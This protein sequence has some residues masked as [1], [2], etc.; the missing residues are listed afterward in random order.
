MLQN[1]T[2]KCDASTSTNDTCSIRLLL[3]AALCSQSDSLDCCGFLNMM[4]I[5]LSEAAGSVCKAVCGEIL[6]ISKGCLWWIM[7][8]Y[9][10]KYLTGHAFDRDVAFHEYSPV[11]EGNQQRLMVQTVTECALLLRPGWMNRLFL[12][13]SW[14]SARISSISQPH[15]QALLFSGRW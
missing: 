12:A 4:G 14:S 15:P 3:S 6:R 13:L 7:A 10:F 9:T 11:V 5:S 2:T 1:A 8:F